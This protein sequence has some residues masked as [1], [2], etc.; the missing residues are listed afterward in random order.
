MSAERTPGGEAASEVILSIFQANGLLLAAGDLLSAGEGLTSAR[1]QVLGAIDAAGRPLTVPQIAR[2]M[3]L[4]R[5]SVHA[6]VKRLIAEGLVELEPNAD[7]RRSQLVRMTEQGARR[8]A[9]IDRLQIAWVNRLARGMRRSDL[10]TARRVLDELC[11]RLRNEVETDVRR[12]A[13]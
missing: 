4:T 9:A 3:G 12:S 8:Y 2:H 13:A 10:E 5:Q 7:H 6:T 1:W 11:A